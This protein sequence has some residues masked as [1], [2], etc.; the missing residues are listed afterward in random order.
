MDNLLFPNFKA[1]FRPADDDRYPWPHT[2][3]GGDHFGRLGR[4][5]DVNAEADDFRPQRQQRFNDIERPLIDIEFYQ[6][7]V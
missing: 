6:A 7:G 1:D 4:V 5:P 2:F 3:E